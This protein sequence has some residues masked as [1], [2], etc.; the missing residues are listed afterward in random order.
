MAVTKVQ[1]LDVSQALLGLLTDVEGLRG[2]SYVS[3]ATRPPACV[4][5]LPDI[6]YADAQSGFCSATWSYPLT[7]VCSRS[8]DLAAQTE[9]SRLLRD[10]VNALGVDVP[11]IFDIRP[12]DAR[13]TTVSLGGQDLPGYL[14]R[15]QVRA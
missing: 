3:D 1:T 15:V 8:N 5:G 10:V 6:D 13:P 11:G 9:L 2:Y 4:I 12:L 7:I 14:L